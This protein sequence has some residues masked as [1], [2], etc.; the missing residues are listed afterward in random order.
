MLVFPTFILYD[1]C[2]FMQDRSCSKKWSLRNA[3]FLKAENFLNQNIL[4]GL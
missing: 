1:S 4:G 2:F 3:R